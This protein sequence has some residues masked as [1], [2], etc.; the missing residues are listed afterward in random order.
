MY[1][2]FYTPLWDG[3]VE[4]RGLEDRVYRVRDYENDREMGEVRGPVARVSARF[5]GHLLIRAAPK[6]D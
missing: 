2:A 1:Y 5:R 6:A 4:L 3:P